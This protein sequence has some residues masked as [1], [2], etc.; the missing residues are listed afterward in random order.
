MWQLAFG[1]HKGGQGGFGFH[2]TLRGRVAMGCLPVDSFHGRGTT[3]GKSQSVTKQVDCSQEDV[4][5]LGSVVGDSASQALEEFLL[6]LLAVAPLACW[7]L[8]RFA[9][10]LPPRWQI[11][12]REL[13][14]GGVGAALGYHGQSGR[15]CP[16]RS[17]RPRQACRSPQQEGRTRQSGA[18]GARMPDR[19][20]D[21]FLLPLVASGGRGLGDGAN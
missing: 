13:L 10:T 18:A 17:R 21:L 4:M 2:E 8:S 6:V 19:C 15:R 16:P 5:N 12:D 7:A 1:R 11:A 14:R 20:G 9:A 3:R